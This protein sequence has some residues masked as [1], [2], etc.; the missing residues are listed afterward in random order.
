MTLI[1]LIP[2]YNSLTE[3]SKQ[4]EVPEHHLRALAQIFATYQVQDVFCLHVLR[5]HSVL[6]EGTV[7]LSSKVGNSG[8]TIW[9]KPTPIHMIAPDRIHGYI[10]ALSPD[11]RL[12]PTEYREGAMEPI[13][14]DMAFFEDLI[15][16]LES[17]SLGDRLGLQVLE[18]KQKMLDFIFEEGIITVKSGYAK[19]GGIYKTTGWR[20]TQDGGIV[21]NSGQ[22]LAK[23]TCLRL[24]EWA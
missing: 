4:Y 16:F 13:A 8:T 6:D 18:S 15:K 2:R 14:A 5:T 23:K 9:T 1:D 7:M 20:I 19:P 21:V 3:D 24:F 10:F 17:N 11:N 12:I 22:S